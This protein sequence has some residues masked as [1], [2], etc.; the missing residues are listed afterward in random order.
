MQLCQK[1]PG[2]FD[3][4]KNHTQCGLN[5]C[6]AYE[7]DREYVYMFKSHLYFIFGILYCHILCLLFGGVYGEV[8]AF[9]ALWVELRDRKSVV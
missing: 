7:R 4:T 9:S 1:D 2:K 6:A 3:D 5:L 8:L